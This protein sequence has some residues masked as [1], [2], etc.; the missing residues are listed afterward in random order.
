MSIYQLQKNQHAVITYLNC[1][2]LNEMGIFENATIKMVSPG[3]PCIIKIKNSK[4]C[5]GHVDILVEPI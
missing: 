1:H 5:I 4:L 3:N 2:K